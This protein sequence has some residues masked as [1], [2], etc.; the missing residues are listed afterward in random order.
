ML[1]F[2]SDTI[3][4]DPIIKHFLDKISAKGGTPIYELSPADARQVLLNVQDIKIAKLPADVEDITIPSTSNGEIKI[5]I[6][7]PKDNKSQLPAIM[8]FHGGGWILGDENTHDRLLRE[9][10]NGAN[11]AVI[12]VKFSRSPEAKYP[13]AIEEAYD[14]TKYIYENGK[15]LNLDSSKLVVMGDS[16]GG[17]MAAVIS[18]LAKERGGLKINYQVLFY[19]VTA[20]DF[21][22]D[23]YNKF[24]T[25][26]WLSKEAMKW[27]WDAYLPDESKRNKYTVSPLL[28]THEQLKGLPPAL[29]ITNEYDVLRDEGEAYAHKLIEAKVKTTAV[30]LLGTIHDCLLINA[31]SDVP[32]IRWAIELTNIKLSSIFKVKI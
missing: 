29:V 23:S 28:A 13:T 12:F 27:F 6:V 10:A 4:V 16:V 18:I 7:R 8:Y 21:E 2:S 20:A 11:A 32:A 24:A 26:Y 14:A 22:T 1:E 9:I 3:I 17:N 19:P 30:R 25:G 31:L 5:R 15:N